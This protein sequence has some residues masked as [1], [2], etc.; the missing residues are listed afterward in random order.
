MG[1]PYKEGR[2]GV[3]TVKRTQK[4][5]NKKGYQVAIAA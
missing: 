2:A 3:K 1:D 4:G 5:G